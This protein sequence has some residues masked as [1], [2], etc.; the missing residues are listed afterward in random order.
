MKPTIKIVSSTKATEARNLL[1]IAHSIASGVFQDEGFLLSIEDSSRI[2]QNSVL[3]T[4]KQATYLKESFDWKHVL[5]ANQIRNWP[6]L[7][8]KR[9]IPAYEKLIDYSVT[10]RNELIHEFKAVVPELSN[11]IAT[12]QNASSLKSICIIFT[13]IGTISCFNNQNEQGVLWIYLREDANLDQLIYCYVNGVLG[14]DT[15]EG[16]W[17]VAQEIMKFILQSP[18]F[19]KVLN[20]KRLTYDSIRSYETSARDRRAS[21]AHFAYLGFPVENALSRE[22]AI[23]KVNNKPLLLSKSERALLF[24]LMDHKEETVTFDDLASAVW[25]D[26]FFSLEA[27]AKIVERIRIKVKKIGVEKNIILTVRKIGYCLVV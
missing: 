22:G 2:S 16:D 18:T 24:C 12:F 21:N 3:L 17:H 23:A 27:L 1:F 14:V 9:F 26:V 5:K 7:E 15:G 25:G 20:K 19:Q 10:S 4:K 11:I 13:S 6:E 8:L